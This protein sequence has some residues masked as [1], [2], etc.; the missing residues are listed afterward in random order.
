[1]NPLLVPTS[2]LI[3]RGGPNEPRPLFRQDDFWVHGINAG[4]TYR[5]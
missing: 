5:Y 1:V 4:I 2:G 3:G